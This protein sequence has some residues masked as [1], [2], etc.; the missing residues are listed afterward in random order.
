M[1]RIRFRSSALAIICTVLFL[2]FL[3]NTIVSVALSNI[4]SS[5][6][7]GVQDLQWVVDAY[8]LVFAVFMLSGGTLG[9]ILGRKKVLLAGVAL[10]T[11]GSLLAAFSK[12]VDLLIA[13]RAVMGLGAAASEP[14]TL[15]I[16]RHLYPERK[17]RSRAL[18][19]WA[20][21]SGIALAFGPIIGGIIISLS[22]WRMVFG[23]GAVLGLVA[24]VG[25]LII[26]PENSDPQGRRFDI[27]GLV[28]GGVALGSIIFALIIGESDG[29]SRWYIELLFAA[30]FMAVLTFIF[31]ERHS[32][33]PVLPLGFFRKIQFS[34]A[35]IVAFA[36]NFGIFSVFFF[37]TL[38]LQLIANFSG[39]QIAIGFIAMT[40]AIVAAA[41]LA[42]RW[43]AIHQTTLLTTAGCLISGGGIFAVN[44]ILN[45]NVNSTDLAWTLGIAGVGFGISLV[46][47][48]STVLNIVEPERSGMAASTVNTSRELGGVFGVAILGSIVNSQLTAHLISQLKAFDIPA[49]FQALVVYAITH[50]GNTP[51][52]VTVSPSLLA[53]HAQLV[54]KLTNAA[55][56]AFGNGLTIALNIA[57]TMLVATGLVCLALYLWLKRKARINPKSASNLQSYV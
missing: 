16:I 44:A 29:Y 30:S 13:S 8:M 18:G 32:R 54:T 21:V 7:A 47:M 45:P 53:T 19:V 48:T 49:S 31:I 35:N 28:S 51:Q 4:Q 11:L 34:I 23:F 57:G 20:A 12:S 10:F 17:S 40:A 39:F 3:D 43:N 33:D 36:T 5:L 56:S 41:L 6:S 9:D 37:V 38:Y 46:T 27:P 42:G 50:G 25:G 2:T 1:K 26:L 22:S 14:G 24:F 15:S 55:Y 52:G